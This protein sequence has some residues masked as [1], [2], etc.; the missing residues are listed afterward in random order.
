MHDTHYIKFVNLNKF[1]KKITF[2][3]LI[4]YMNI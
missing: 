1:I 4:V 3:L 2:I